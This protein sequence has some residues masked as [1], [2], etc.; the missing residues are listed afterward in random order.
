MC[1]PKRERWYL[2]VSPLQLKQLW[3]SDIMSDEDLLVLG[4]TE[5]LQP[6]AHFIHTPRTHC[7]HST[8]VCYTHARGQRS[9]VKGQVIPGMLRA[10]HVSLFLLF[11]SFLNLGTRRNLALRPR[12]EKSDSWPCTQTHIRPEHTHQNIPRS[13][14]CHAPRRRPARWADWSSWCLRV[15]V[16]AERL[17]SA[18]RSADLSEEDPAAAET[19]SGNTQLSV[20]PPHCH[21]SG[22]HHLIYII[23]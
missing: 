13:A 9:K 12:L 7:S 15:C 14:G 10:A 17:N 18:H 8:R 20:N 3:S 11:L 22:V 23:I 4:Q 16:T 6:D 5:H 1:L 19:R 2:Q 21:Y